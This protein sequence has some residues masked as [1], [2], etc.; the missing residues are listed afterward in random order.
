MKG[1]RFEWFVLERFAFR[2][3]VPEY[4]FSDAATF[5]KSTTSLGASIVV[6]LLALLLSTPARADFGADTYKAKCAACHGAKGLGDTMLGRNLKIP[7]LGSTEVQTKSDDELI[8]IISKG[9]KRMPP[10]DRKLSKEEIR[11]VLKFV[12]ALKK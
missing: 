7:A 12:R 4:R 2:R 1:L 5:R 6:I 10:F 9:K 8:T 3:F 11:D